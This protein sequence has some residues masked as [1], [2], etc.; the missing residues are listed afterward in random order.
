MELLRGRPIDL[1]R[2]EFARGDVIAVP[3]M[4]TNLFPLPPGWTIRR[5]TIDV[6]PGGWLA[7]MDSRIG[8]GFYAD[9]FGPLPFVVGPAAMP[10]FTIY[11]VQTRDT[12]R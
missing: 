5:E 11:E 9:V 1:R 6:A 10:R 3:T 4:N 8:A 7:T 2:S 12:A